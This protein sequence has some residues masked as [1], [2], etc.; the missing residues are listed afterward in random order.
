[1]MP[2][3]PG[4][5]AAPHP[6]WVSKHATHMQGLA[7]VDQVAY[8]RDHWNAADLGA[9][10]EQMRALRPRGDRCVYCEDNEGDEVDHL[11]PRTLH[12]TLA[13]EP[14]NLICACGTCGGSAHK[15][16]RDAN[17]T[18]SGAP[19]WS[20]IS[21]PPRAPITQPAQGAT[22][23][24]NPRRADPMRG[25][26]L[27]LGD[28]SFLFEPHPNASPTDRA[29]ATWTIEA[30]GLNT[31]IALV[32]ARGE[33]YELKLGALEKAAKPGAN[34]GNLA[35]K[36][37]HGGHPTVWAEMKRQRADIPELAA[38]FAA[39]PAALGW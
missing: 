39:V 24:W 1:M 23:W 26:W 21:R 31:R 30:L 19:G 14:L 8:A 34:I 11:R 7:Y 13:W 16:A 35:R 38:A 29:R 27:S 3:N 28:R 6:T 22:A 36:L 33:A 18:P 2:F 17:L 20:E 4:A 9:Y 37:Q 10:R 5:P 15:G 12:P 25:L 32:N